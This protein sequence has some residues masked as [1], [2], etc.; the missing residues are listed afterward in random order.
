MPDVTSGRTFQQLFSLSEPSEQNRTILVPISSPLYTESARSSLPKRQ[1]PAFSLRYAKGGWRVLA[2]YPSKGQF[3]CYPTLSVQA[4]ARLSRNVNLLTQSTCQHLH[5]SAVTILNF[6]LL[7][8]LSCFAS[9]TF[10]LSPSCCN[11]LNS[12]LHHYAKIITYN[13]L[14]LQPSYSSKDCII[15]PYSSYRKVAA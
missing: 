2:E 10:L 12:F 9:N 8:N 3:I 7:A 11:N 15:I 13:I 1:F 5:T 6:S 14:N 4:T